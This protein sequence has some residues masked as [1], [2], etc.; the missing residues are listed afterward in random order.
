[1]LDNVQ[2]QREHA[3]V[4]NHRDILTSLSRDRPILIAGPTA[5]GKSA[6]AMSI[7]ER[8]GGLII[9][10]DALQVFDD[11][12]ILTARPSSADEAK[13]R[14]CLYGHVPGDRAYSVGDWLREIAPLITKEPRPIIVGGTGLYFTALT[15]GLAEIP[16][17]P[18]EIRE[19]ANQRRRR[20]GIAGMLGEIDPETR[21]KIDTNNPMRVQRA[22]EVQTTTGRGLSD[23]HKETGAP[24][25]PLEAAHPLVLDAPRDWLTPRIAARFQLMLDAGVLDEARRNQPA[26][27]PDLPSAKAIGAAQ[28]MEYLR[29][30]LSIDALAERIAVLTRQYAKRQRTWFRARM[31]D[32]TWLDCH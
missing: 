16:P 10:A 27:S 28:L 9:N 32:W 19:D 2:R 30:D 23:W 11:W 15:E 4:N 12:R 6:L 17:T 1:M 26:W 14:H 5:S 29:G 25:L 13:A 7:A 22:W 18:A 8:L 21:A 20:D 31:T 3:L 24:L